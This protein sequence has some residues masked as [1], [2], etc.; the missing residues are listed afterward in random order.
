MKHQRLLRALSSS[1]MMFSVA[2]GDDGSAAVDDGTGTAS[3]DGRTTGGPGESMTAAEVTTGGGTGDAS[4]GTTGGGSDSTSVTTEG[5]TTDDTGP[6]ETTGT[7]GDETT[8]GGVIPDPGFA[9]CIDEPAAEVCLATENCFVDDPDLV[10]WG[11]CS[12]PSCNTADDCPSPPSGGN[13]VVSCI[14][15][16]GDLQAECVLGCADNRVCPDGM[17]C[18]DDATCAWP[19]G[20]VSAFDGTLC[21]DYGSGLASCDFELD[22]SLPF[23]GQLGC[24]ATGDDFLW[25]VFLVELEADDCVSVWADNIDAAD[26][27]TGSTAGDLLMVVHNQATDDGFSLEDEV[28]CSDPAFEGFACPRGGF[29]V[30]DSGVHEIGVAQWGAAG[31]PNPSPYTVY[32]TINGVPFDLGTV[33]MSVSDYPLTCTL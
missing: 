9:N 33:G 20:F 17:D 23:S 18:I 22:T 14:D 10:L 2:C 5:S 19:S 31:C 15:L 7:A 16:D 32:V 3:T 30:S 8:T 11:F 26:G 28:E 21:S 6:G 29:I 4:G 24:D 27:P 25:D 13:P 12:V 1:C